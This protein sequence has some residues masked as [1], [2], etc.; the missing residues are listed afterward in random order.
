MDAEE[1]KLCMSILRL[2]YSVHWHEINNNLYNINQY[3][4]CLLVYIRKDI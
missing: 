4:M 2:L 1:L 3:S